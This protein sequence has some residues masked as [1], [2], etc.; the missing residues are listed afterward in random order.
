MPNPFRKVAAGTYK[1]VTKADV[2]GEIVVLEVAFSTSSRSRSLRSSRGKCPR[3]GSRSSKRPLRTLA[4]E[5]PSQ[6]SLAQNVA[7]HGFLQTPRGNVAC[8]GEHR[9]E[10]E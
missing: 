7:G 9:V 3:S 6:T 1:H 8:E 10:R 4:A 5:L 2:W